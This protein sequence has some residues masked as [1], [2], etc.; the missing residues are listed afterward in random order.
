VAS[1]KLNADYHYLH[2]TILQEMGED[3]EAVASLNRAVFLNPNHVAAHFALGNLL[4]RMGNRKQSDRHLKIALT[5]L[6]DYGD[7]DAV[8]STEGM[9]ARRLTEIILSMTRKE[10]LA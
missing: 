1:D 6:G 2:A 7:D 5:I 9:N 8:P 10:R 3:Q 4:L